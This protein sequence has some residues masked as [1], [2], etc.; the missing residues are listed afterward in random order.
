MTVFKMK[1]K[2]KKIKKYS[3]FPNK[4][5]NNKKKKIPVKVGINDPPK[6]SKH[7]IIA[8]DTG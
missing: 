8:T 6:K 1:E 5:N 2:L 7:H 4:N 3:M